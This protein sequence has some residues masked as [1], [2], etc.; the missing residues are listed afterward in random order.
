MK[1]G[2]L[3]EYGGTGAVYIVLWAD[4]EHMKLMGFGDRLFKKNIQDV[5]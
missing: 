5:R 3:V 1:T 2:D 4:E